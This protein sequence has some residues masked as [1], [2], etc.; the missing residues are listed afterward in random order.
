MLFLPYALDARRLGWP[1]VTVTVMLLCLWVFREQLYQ[2]AQFSTRAGDFCRG[3]MEWVTKERVMTIARA[4]GH[5]DCVPFFEHL[6][7]LQPSREQ[8]RELVEQAP[9]L[10]VFADEAQDRD[11]QLQVLESEWERYRT[12]VPPSLTQ[13]LAYDPQEPDWKRMLTSTLS[14]GDWFHIGGNLLFFY[15]FASALESV[16]GTLRFSLLL[17][18]SAVGTSLAYTQATRHLA[19]A[20][21]TIGLSGVVMATIA[22]LAV[23]L[24]TVRVRC[25]FWFFVIFRTFRVPAL[26][27]ALWY[28]GWDYYGL[29]TEGYTAMINYTAHL[30]GALLGALAG[31]GFRVFSSD[32]LSRVV[33]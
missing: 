29:K 31:L 8:L 27:L 16:L 2:D 20:L 5:F 18:L 10:G 12:L 1:W 11:Y 28:V 17:V 33:D 13:R 3:Q 30:S 15:I 4:S 32:R 21:P 22:A 19:E 23:M 6:R 25:F 9:P 26:L 7:S 14:H 24:P